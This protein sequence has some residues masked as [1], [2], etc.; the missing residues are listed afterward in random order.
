MTSNLLTP[1]GATLTLASGRVV[2]RAII[3][4]RVSTARENMKSH[5]EQAHICR[6]F[7]ASKGIEIVGDPV[8]DLDLSGADFAKRKISECIERVRNGEAD[9]IVVWEYSRFGRTL[10]GSLFYIRELEA[11]GGEL[12]SATQDIDASTPA[13]RYMRDQFLRLAEYQLDMIRASWMSAHARRFREGLPHSGAPRFGYSRCPGCEKPRGTRF[14]VCKNN[15]AGILLPDADLPEENQPAVLRSKWLYKGYEMIV[16]GQSFYRLA[17]EA[18][19][20]GVTSL[21]GN[22]MRENQWRAVLDSGFGA[23]LLRARS[24]K[25]SRVTN[26]NPTT[27]DI[28]ADAAHKAIAPQDLWDAYVERRARQSDNKTRER[29][30]K[31][32]LSSLVRCGEI[33]TDGTTCFEIMTVVGGGGGKDRRGNPKPKIKLFRCDR[34]DKHKSGKTSSIA[35]HRLDGMVFEWLQKSARGEE[36]AQISMERAAKAAESDS[37]IP[38]MEDIIRG[39]ERKKNRINEGYEA[40]LTTLEEAKARMAAVKVELEE[41]QSKL[42][43]LKA[44]AASNRVPALEAF[45]GLAAVWERATPEER[46]RALKK[47]IDHVRVEDPE[48]SAWHGRSARVVPLWADESERFF[49]RRFKRV[50]A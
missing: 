25:T 17:T 12:L 35:M 2:R 31:Y 4:V 21:R 46:R 28:W 34:A 7:C 9:A 48:I 30:P 36:M 44:E 13:G 50:T 14:Y 32:T 20:A 23:G 33:C 18:W 15:C 42:R 19:Q 16:D 24:D 8:E 5:T 6:F 10:V 26:T 38:V 47:I 41:N 11:A 43:R 27:Y 3:Y 49:D 22:R 45:Q 40:G 37:Q 29:E 39:L 1:P